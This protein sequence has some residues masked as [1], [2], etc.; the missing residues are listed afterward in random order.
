[1]DEGRATQQRQ[2]RWAALVAAEERLQRAPVAVATAHAQLLRDALEVARAYAVEGQSLSIEPQ[3][4]LLLRCSTAKADRLLVEAST[5]AEL[6]GGFAALDE[7]LLT[8]EQSAVAARELDRV[9]D[10]PTRLAVWRQ[11]LERPRVDLQARAVLPPP[12]LRELLRRWVLEA[13]PEDAEEQREDAAAE[14]RVEY[15]RRDDGLAD[16]YLIG[17]D[18]SLA[19]AVLIRVREE[20]APVSSSDDRT[21]DQRR[22]DAAV[23]LLLGRVGQHPCGPGGEVQAVRPGAGCGCLPGTP[24]PCG[25]Q[26][27]VFVPLGAALGSTQAVAELS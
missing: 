24:V 12:R 18:A 17:M 3:V 11:L 19:Q 13:A 16:V 23:D 5:L 10:L 9:P 7:G 6:P 25:A 21:A 15:R 26:L 27:L 20:S 1:M 8:V 14:R 4:A 22:L 2:E